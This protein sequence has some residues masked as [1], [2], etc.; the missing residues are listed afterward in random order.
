MITR[1]NLQKRHGDLLE[2]MPEAKH[3]KAFISQV[4]HLLKEVPEA[5][6]HRAFISQMIESDPTWKWVGDFIEDVEETA[7]IAAAP[8]VALKQEVPIPKTYK[9]AVE[10]PVWGHMWKEAIEK[11]LIALDSNNTWTEVHPPKGANLVTSKWVFDVKRFISGAIEKFKA[12]LVARG[13]SQKFRVD[14]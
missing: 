2:D 6:Q 3:H 7:F 5:G 4:I 14:F 1:N 13:F 10:D 12:R 8:K 11:E 9:E